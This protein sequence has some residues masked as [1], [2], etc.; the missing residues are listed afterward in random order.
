[1]TLKASEQTELLSGQL[2][3]IKKIFD[4]MV[5]PYRPELW[6][7]CYHITGSPWDAE[8]LVQDTLLKA[9]SSLSHLWQPINPKGYLF[10]IA[11]TTW[12][13]QCRKMKLKLEPIETTYELPS[14]EDH[15]IG[16][17]EDAFAHLVTTLAPRQRV[18]LLLADVFS[19]KLKEVAEIVGAN[20]GTV[21]ALLHRARKKLKEAKESNKERKNDEITSEQ[22][23]LISNYMAAFNRRDPEG[24]A[25]LLE[26]N[27]RTDIVHI[28][29]ELGKEV[30][31]K[32]SLTDW[33][34][35]PVDMKAELHHLWG[36]PTIVQV[37]FANGDRAVYNLNRLD[38]ENGKI[39][40]IK[41]YYFCPELLRAAANQLMMKVFP[42]KYT[43][44]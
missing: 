5:I 9:F 21:K 36:R 24:I 8:D 17:I 19:F 29:Q 32:H 22:K 27:V 11:S 35:D 1:M 14:Y 43:L 40:A 23:E 26:H 20:E 15:Y 30:V 44:Q 34:N 41:D 2:R 7:Y 25:K 16:E 13:D 18:A 38:W 28:A 33:A 6:R 39:V 10:K 4:E 31:V 37:A 12:I 3:D 42:R